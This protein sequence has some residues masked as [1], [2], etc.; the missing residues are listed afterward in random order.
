MFASEI[1]SPNP[2]ALLPVPARHTPL[3]NSRINIM[4]SSP[5][6]ARVLQLN[7]RLQGGGTDTQ[8]L[9]LS[10]GLSHLGWTIEVAGPI[11]A[12]LSPSAQ[13]FGFH[14]LPRFR[15]H[16]IFTLAGVLRRTKPRIL[17]AHHGDDYWTALLASRLVEPRP[18]VI[19]SRHLAKS[20]RSPVSRK[21]LFAKADAVIAVSSF[22][23]QVLLQGH[24]DPASPVA[25][26][27]HRPSCTI[28]PQK[29]HVIHTGID[30]A[31]FRPMDS[32]FA[33]AARHR[34]SLNK[35][36][37]VFG[38]V[39]GFDLPVGKGQRVFLKAAQMMV[40]RLPH[41]RFLLAGSGTMEALLR[42]DIHHLGLEDRARLI[43]QQ[44]DPVSLHHAIDCLVHP[45]IATE[46]FPSVVL[47]AH[48]CGRPVL[49]SELDGIPE[50]WS[51]GKLG[52]LVRAGDAGALAQAMVAFSENPG[53]THDERTAAHTRVASQASQPVQ[54]QRVA[55]LYRRL[56]AR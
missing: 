53:L 21:H 16:Q 8:S 11:D 54:A 1:A 7:S 24:D 18:L 49:A 14:P 31:L 28:A 35:N 45:Q 13:K 46:A 12:P 40:R 36:E 44:P 6:T 3:C 50:A 5:L 25:E 15:P 27:H 37:L 43:G 17:H 32:S 34:L 56:M 29:L 10:R 22:V 42:D 23:A 9:A 19:F 52:Q 48:A 41:A 20:P 30:T 55:D 47:E 26:R 39:G 51:I 38:V 33:S 2:I 4:S